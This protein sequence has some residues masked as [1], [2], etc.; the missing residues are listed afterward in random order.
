MLRRNAIVSIS[1]LVHVALHR[2]GN[3]LRESADA[4]GLVGIT[5]R[6]HPARFDKLTNKN[7]RAD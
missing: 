2:V 5:S 4:R 3:E 7:P 1:L 6:F